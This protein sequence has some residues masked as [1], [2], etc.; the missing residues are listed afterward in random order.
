[1]NQTKLQHCKQLIKELIIRCE[2]PEFALENYDRET[3][4]QAKKEVLGNG[5]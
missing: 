3:Y 1:M 4:D 5:I 2:P